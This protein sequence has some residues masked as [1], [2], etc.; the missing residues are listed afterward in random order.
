VILV[1]PAFLLYTLIQAISGISVSPGATIRHAALFAG[2]AAVLLAARRAVLLLRRR[3]W[4]AALPLLIVGVAQAAIGIRQHSF[5]DDEI[6]VRGTFHNRNH[7]AG[8][9]EMALPLAAG[10]VVVFARRVD[11][12]AGGGVRAALGAGACAAAALVIVL[13][14]VYSLSRA[15]FGAAVV[16]MV[17]LGTGLLPRRVRLPGAVVLAATVVL[18]LAWLAP[19]LLFDRFG[20]LAGETQR[21]WLWRETVEMIRERP[22]VG[23]GFGAYGTA[24]VARRGPLP[25]FPDV[26]AHN[27]YLQLAAELGVV[28][29][30]LLGA[31]TLPAARDVLRAAAGDRDR[32]RTV[33][34]LACLAGM[35]ALATHSLVDFQL[36]VPANLLSFAWLAGTACGVSASLPETASAAST[37]SR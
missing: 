23:W 32:N 29:L 22:L 20:R 36:Y 37:A 16:G 21:V 9:L 33:L 6:H 10:W 31:A 30:L 18:G 28:G 24:L 34:A 4:L 2:C 15:A 5:G 3:A 1:F 27:D 14:I 26:Y 12:R 35:A 17:A 11:P 13:G 8:F 7:F 19:A 25:D